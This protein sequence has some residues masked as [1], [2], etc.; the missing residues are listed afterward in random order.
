MLNWKC[1]RAGRP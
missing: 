1:Y